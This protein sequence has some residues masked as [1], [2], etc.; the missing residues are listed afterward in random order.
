MLAARPAAV[1]VAAARA[2]AVAPVAELM[3]IL[4]AGGVAAVSPNGVLGDPT[5]AD[6]LAGR[7]LLDAWISALDAYVAACFSSGRAPG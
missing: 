2:G 3:S 6:P 7:A 1:R 5:G 4:R